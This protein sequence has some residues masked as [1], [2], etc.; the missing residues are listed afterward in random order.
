MT[1]PPPYRPSSATQSGPWV[2]AILSAPWTTLLADA[3]L[4]IACS[5]ALRLMQ[6]MQLDQQRLW[7][8][9][10]FICMRSTSINSWDVLHPQTRLICA[11]NAGRIASKTFG[12]VRILP[13]GIWIS[14]LAFGIMFKAWSYYLWIQTDRVMLSDDEDYD[15]GKED[16][17]EPN[18]Y[19]VKSVFIHIIFTSILLAPM[20]F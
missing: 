5:T 12:V 2:T 19:L 1:P 4:T 10:A 8:Q 11:E 6:R 16:P 20:Y 9:L 15:A 13:L 7:A 14:L 3:L 17:V 18:D